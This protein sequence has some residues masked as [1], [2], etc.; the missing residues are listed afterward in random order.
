MYNTYYA[1]VLICIDRLVFACNEY[2]K[3][4]E[5]RL[6]IENALDSCRSVNRRTTKLSLVKECNYIKLLDTTPIILQIVTNT[7]EDV[8]VNL[9][10]LQTVYKVLCAVFIAMILYTWQLF[11]SRMSEGGT[12]LPYVY[13]GIKKID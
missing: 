6:G 11:Y 3:L 9:C 13:K 2:I 7:V 12:V 4:S 1:L 8:K 5:E 10:S